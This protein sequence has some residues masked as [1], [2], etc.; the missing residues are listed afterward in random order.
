MNQQKA[1]LNQL[2]RASG[3]EKRHAPSYWLANKQTIALIAELETTGIPVVRLEGRNGG[4]FV[5]REQVYAYAMWISASLNL[6]VI[7]T[8]P[9][10]ARPGSP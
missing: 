2:N 3:G 8:N 6:R 7:R 9:V 10:L 4:T 5:C 1:R